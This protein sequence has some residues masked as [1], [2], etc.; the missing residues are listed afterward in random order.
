VPLRRVRGLIL[1]LVRRRPAAVVAGLSLAA[2][3]AWLELGGPDAWWAEGLSLVLGATGIA[4]IWIG[5]VGA[6]P[7][8]ID[9][10]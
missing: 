7:D 3:A 5:V 6:T 1:R 4:L 10:T 2:P 8:W 9:E